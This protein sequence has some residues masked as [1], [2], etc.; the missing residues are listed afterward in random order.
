MPA[1]P[2]HGLACLSRHAV[3]PTTLITPPCPTTGPVL[4]L[5]LQS[6]LNGFQHEQPDY[7]LTFGNP[8]EI[9]RFVVNYPI[10]YY[11]HVSAQTEDGKQVF[12]WNAGEQ[13]R[14]WQ[15]GE[16]EGHGKQLF[17]WSR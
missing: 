16:G 9:E 2:W 15:G 8:W 14:G 4:F 13:V 10:K 1:T 7:W 3:C 11:G 12:K 5:P 17:K 6:I